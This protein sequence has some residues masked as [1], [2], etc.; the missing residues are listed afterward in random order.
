[1]LL[2]F[3]DIVSYQPIPCSQGKIDGV[4]GLCLQDLMDRINILN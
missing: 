2:K 3:Y 1:M 4:G